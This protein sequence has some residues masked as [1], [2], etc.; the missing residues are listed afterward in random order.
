[1]VHSWKVD[2]LKAIFN[3]TSIA[4]IGASDKPRKLG[5][6]TLRAIKAAG[7]QGKVFLVHP[8]LSKIGD[9]QVYSRI[10]KRT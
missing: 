2:A 8:S 1:M 6:L 9:K 3:P 4:I 5:S 10:H 7:Y